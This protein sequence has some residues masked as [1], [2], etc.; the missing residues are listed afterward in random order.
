MDSV[1][2]IELIGKDLLN[3]VELLMKVITIFTFNYTRRG[4]F[5]KHKL[6]VASLLCLRV[7]VRN[8]VVTQSEVDVRI[9]TRYEIQCG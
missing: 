6:I 4:L 9:V 7:L 2:V 3:R 8:K 1:K 5:D